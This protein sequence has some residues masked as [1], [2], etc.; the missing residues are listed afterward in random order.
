MGLALQSLRASVSSDGSLAV[1]RDDR[2]AHVSFLESPN[3]LPGVLG[4]PL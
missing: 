3:G 1:G 2:I 4:S